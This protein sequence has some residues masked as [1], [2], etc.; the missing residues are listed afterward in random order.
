MWAEKMCGEMNVVGNECG[1]KLL[2]G[3]MIVVENECQFKWM[4]F[5]KNME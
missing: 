4:W 2:R 3:Q 5:E 1:F